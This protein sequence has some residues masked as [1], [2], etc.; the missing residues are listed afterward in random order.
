M[1]STRFTSTLDMSFRV[2]LLLTAAG[3][4]ALVAAMHLKA[5]RNEV[6]RRRIKALTLKAVQRPGGMGSPA[7][8][9]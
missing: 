4:T 7:A 9:G 8:T 5:M 3:F 6:L 1:P 2:P